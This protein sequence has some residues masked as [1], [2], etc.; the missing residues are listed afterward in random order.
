MKSKRLISSRL[1][2]KIMFGF[3]LT[4]IGCNSDD[5][6]QG[7]DLAVSVVDADGNVLS[8][9]SVTIYLTRD[10]WE[11]GI[12]SVDF[13]TTNTNGM[14][15]F[16]SLEPQSYFIEALS[17]DLSNWDG[18]VETSVLV[19]N[20]INE[21]KLTITSSAT[22]FLVG[23]KEKSY[24]ITDL[25]ISNVSIFSELDACERDNVIF[26]QRDDRLGLEDFGEN[27]CE[28]NEERQVAFTWDF[29]TDGSRLLLDYED[30]Q[31]F[32]YTLIS[33]SNERFTI[34][35]TIPFDGQELLAEVDFS[36][37]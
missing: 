30:G 36:V 27:A 29:S 15:T 24:H 1:L 13:G 6:V 37:L 4:I 31:F 22:N 28:Q 2:Y 19:A 33:I 8:G 3:C 26:F 32:D 17:G 20:N 9:I 16:R 12:N 5:S 14:I 35:T 7:T 11:E 21:L 23:K 25:K 18:T 10:D 34:E